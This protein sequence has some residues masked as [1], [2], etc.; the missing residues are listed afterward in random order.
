[1]TATLVVPAPAGTSVAENQRD[2]FYRLLPELLAEEPRA[3]AVFADIGYGYLDPDAVAPVRDR[4]VNVGIREQLLI[5][6]AGGLALAGLRPIVHTFA[7]FLVERPF[8]QVKL[9]IGHQGSGAVLVSAG[10]S[11]DWPAGGETHMGRRD[12]ALLDTL[13]GW[14]V[15]VPG[16][17]DEVEVLLRAAIPGDGR[18]YL[19]LGGTS[20]AVARPVADGR[21]QV[22]RRGF[23][24]T[25]IAVGPLADRVLEATADLDVTVL[26]AATVRPFDARTLRATLGEPDVVLVE[27][28]LR[29]TSTAE[30]ARALRGTR[31]RVLGLGPGPQELRRYGTVDDHDAAHGLDVAGLRHAITTFVGSG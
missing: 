2:R 15:H 31:H 1:M 30:V 3:V 8:E 18:V 13:D 26:Y 19:R 11:H 24:P 17:P 6:A 9:D 27:P 7:P 14:T 12:V 23:G 16:H 4:V 5:G 22:L 28:Y 10:G 20:N 25:V 21:M 29:D